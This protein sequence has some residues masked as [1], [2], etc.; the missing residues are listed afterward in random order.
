MDT[1]AASTALLLQAAE[2]FGSTGKKSTKSV[3]VPDKLCV[4]PFVVDAELLISVRTC[5]VVTVF[6]HALIMVDTA[7]AVPDSVV[8]RLD[9]AQIGHPLN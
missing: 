4:A 9:T 3:P 1:V 7:L 2:A 6:C 5:P 8:C